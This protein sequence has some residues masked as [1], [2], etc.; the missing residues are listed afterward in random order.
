MIP[1][2][3]EKLQPKNTEENKTSEFLVNFASCNGPPSKFDEMQSN[4]VEP[5]FNFLKWE[6]CIITIMVLLM[7]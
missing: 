6:Y 3:N 1:K 5:V 4:Q 7:L 2:T